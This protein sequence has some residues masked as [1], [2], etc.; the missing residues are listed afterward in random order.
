M[1]RG[2]LGG[3]GDVRTVRNRMQWGEV[4]HRSD[5]PRS[6]G[7]QVINGTTVRSSTSDPIGRSSRLPAWYACITWAKRIRMPWA[8]LSETTAPVVAEL[9]QKPE[10]VEVVVTS[11]RLVTS[12]DTGKRYHDLSAGA[13][14]QPGSANAGH[15]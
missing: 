15:W 12:G 14:S 11:F 13:E 1:T 4:L 3:A 2:C 10:R 5:R 8:Q 6:A 7:L 9:P